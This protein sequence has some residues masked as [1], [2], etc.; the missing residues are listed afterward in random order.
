MPGC[1][2]ERGQWFTLLDAIS[3]VPLNA[4]V[5]QFEKKHQGDL[6]PA[7]LVCNFCASKMLNPSFTG[8]YILRIIIHKSLMLGQQYL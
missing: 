8:A 1:V 7:P 6:L 4:K 2:R 5:G 3:T